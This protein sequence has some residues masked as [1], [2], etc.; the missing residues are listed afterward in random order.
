[1]NEFGEVVDWLWHI[2]SCDLYPKFFPLFSNAL[3]LHILLVLELLL[4]KGL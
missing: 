3:L 2:D 1:M 4:I